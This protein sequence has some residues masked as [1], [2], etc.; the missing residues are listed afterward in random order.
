MSSNGLGLERPG[1][2][3]GHGRVRF[4]RI[5]AGAQALGAGGA[6]G[7]E[8]LDVRQRLLQAGQELVV[9]SNG[10]VEQ[11][12]LALY[13][14]LPGVELGP[15]AVED[16]HLLGVEDDAHLGQRETEQ[17]LQVADRVTRAMSAAR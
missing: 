10:G 1:S 9:G 17:V 8:G 16:V 5:S 11:F 7:A 13:G 15:D 6:L 4:E 14:R 3:G 12:A 2:G